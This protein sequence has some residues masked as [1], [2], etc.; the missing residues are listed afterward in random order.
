[1]ASSNV[2]TRSP[3]FAQRAAFGAPVFAQQN[4]VITACAN[5]STGALRLVFAGSTCKNN[6]APVTWNSTGPAG[7]RGPAGATGPAGPQ[8]EPGDDNVIAVGV[9]G[10]TATSKTVA[11]VNLGDVTVSCNDAGLAAFNLASPD[12]FQ[13]VQR[14]N[15]DTSVSGG[16]QPNGGT[17]SFSASFVL[18]NSL[19]S[20]S[21]P[22][23]GLWQIE[24]T[25]RGKTP[26]FTSTLE[27]ASSAI[28][29]VIH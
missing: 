21:K 29:T 17:I 19:I 14:K 3:S 12:A 8:G 5:I 11:I 25:L 7:P 24:V 10:L 23:G 16:V 22:G 28:V 4:T 13:F 9:H 26:I 27:C 2:G 6:E 15:V 18:E 20:V 1:M